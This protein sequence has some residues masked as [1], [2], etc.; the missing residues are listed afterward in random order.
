MS[1]RFLNNIVSVNV[2]EQAWFGALYDNTAWDVVVPYNMKMRFSSVDSLFQGIGV[3]Q[4]NWVPARTKM[5]QKDHP[6]LLR[7]NFGVQK[8]GLEEM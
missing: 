1:E 2:C 4:V 7:L 6:R 3:S 8:W 5:V